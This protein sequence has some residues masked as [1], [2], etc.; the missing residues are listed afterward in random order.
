[1]VVLLFLFGLDVL[2]SLLLGVGEQ[3]LQAGAL[4]LHLL[5]IELLLLGLL[6]LEQRR[7]RSTLLVHHFLELGR[8]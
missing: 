3:L 1:M 4:L 8:C 6:P 7:P 2:A 5:H